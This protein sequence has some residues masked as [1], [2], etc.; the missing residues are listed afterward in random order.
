MTTE[1]TVEIIGDL[2][3]SSNIGIGITTPNTSSVLDLTSTTGALIVSRMTTTER[4]ALTATDG[5]I[6]YNITT[7]AFNFRENGVWVSGSG[8]V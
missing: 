6:I 5:M 7:P 4:N 1:R 2:I 8:L 3:V